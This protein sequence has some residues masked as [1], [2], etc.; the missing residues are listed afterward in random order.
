M[1]EKPKVGDIAT[2]KDFV[3]MLI[4]YLMPPVPNFTQKITVITY[5]GF[6]MAIRKDARMGL[7]QWRAR[8]ND[9]YMPQGNLAAGDRGWEWG[10]ALWGL[11]S[12]AQ[13]RAKSSNSLNIND[14]TTYIP[15]FYTGQP[16]PFGDSV[17]SKI[18]DPADNTIFQGVDKHTIQGKVPVPGELIS[19]DDIRKM[20]NATGKTV[21]QWTSVYVYEWTNT[22]FENRRHHTPTWYNPGGSAWRNVNNFSYQRLDNPLDAN[23]SNYGLY[24]RANKKFQP[25]ED[26]LITFVQLQNLLS[27]MYSDK[28]QGKKEIDH[29]LSCHINCHHNCHSMHW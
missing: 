1:S 21:Y 15:T 5:S 3:D 19:A 11:N 8:G 16:R 12:A 29:V 17:V 23:K 9:Y 25:S 26:E 20:L 14:Y 18:I 13:F 4:Y 22:S 10:H 2:V 6:R 27:D 7:A 28:N 24:D